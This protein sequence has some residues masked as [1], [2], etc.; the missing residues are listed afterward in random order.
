MP[1]TST[2]EK[3]M[4]EET[5][6]GNVKTFTPEENE[7][8]LLQLNEGMPDFLQENTVARTFSEKELAN[9]VLD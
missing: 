1:L 2:Y 5:A 7:R 3:I 9:I 6:K 8:I 4:A